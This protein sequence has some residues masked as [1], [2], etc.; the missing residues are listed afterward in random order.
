VNEPVG[1]IDNVH[2]GDRAA[3]FEIGTIGTSASETSADRLV[4]ASKKIR[5][6]WAGNPVTPAAIRQ[7]RA[8]AQMGA[9]V[10][11]DMAKAGVPILA[12][13][14]IGFAGFC[15]HDELAAMVRGGM[16]PLGALQ[17]ATLNPARYFNLQQ[18]GGGVTAG[19]RADL[20]LLDANPLSDIANVRSIRAVV[21][22]GRMLDREELDKML[23]EVTVIASR[24]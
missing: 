1:N 8:R 22:A 14:D 3:A 12:G 10:T 5:D 7:F 17:T 9:T 23:A 15:V 6:A 21:L 11:S 24:Q 4:Y 19:R 2:M 16:T 13:C 18:S 20:V